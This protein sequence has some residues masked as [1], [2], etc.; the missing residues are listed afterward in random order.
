MVENELLNVFPQQNLDKQLKITYSGGTITN[1]E[2][3]QESMELTES[4]CSEEELR[5]G[6]CE[7]SCFKIRV[8]NVFQ[9]MQGEWIDVSMTLEGHPNCAH[10]IGHYKVASDVPTADRVWR[11]ITAYDAMYDIINADVVGWYDSIVKDENAK[12][13]MREFRRSFVQHF[14]LEEA[15]PSMALVN[16]NMTIQRTV[17]AE[18]ISGKDMLSCICEINGCFPHIDQNGKMKYIY[19]AQYIQGL[20]PADDLYPDHAPYYLPY[21]QETGHLYPKDPKGFNVGAH[22][23]YISC[24]YEDFLT[25][26]IKRLQVHMQENE[27][28]VIV[29]QDAVGNSYK[30]AGNFLAY[31]KGSDELR[32]IAENIMAKIR[33]VIYRPY[34]AVTQG[35]LCVEVGDTVRLGTRYEAVESYVL[36]RHLTGIQALRDTLTATGV[37]EYTEQVNDVHT[38]ILELRGKSNTLSR[39]IE[40]TKSELKDDDAALSTRITQ[41]AKDIKAEAEERSKADEELSASITINAEAIE[42]EVNDRKKQG[43]ELS[44]RIT[45][46]AKN[47]ELFVQQVSGQSGEISKAMIEMAAGVIEAKVSKNGSGNTNNEVSFQLSAAEDEIRIKA[48]RLFVE[49]GYIESSKYF[50]GEIMSKEKSGKW[51]SDS[52][53]SDTWGHTTYINLDTGDFSFGGGQFYYW[54]NEM[55]LDGNFIASGTITGMDFVG[56]RL[57]NSD[58]TNY[59]DFGS[60]QMLIG[61]KSGGDYLE[62][63]NGTLTFSGDLS[64]AGGTFSGKLSAAGGTFSGDISAANGTFKGAV[65]SNDAETNTTLL[66]DDGAIKF[67]LNDSESG[68]LSGWWMDLDTN[69]NMLVL[70]SYDNIV[71]ASPKVSTTTTPAPNSSGSHITYST[72]LNQTV[73]VISDITNNDDSTISWHYANLTFT[74]G[75][76]TGVTNGN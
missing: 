57:Q 14:G 5:F 8:A 3:C 37:E 58:G 47:I 54:N 68:Y 11:D 51:E 27:I 72:G 45:Q 69:R 16:D 30:I 48:G 59:L 67:S 40:E 39:T 20:Y 19:L 43:D 2:I 26:E 33:G 24:K 4:L 9:P 55:H 50:A 53:W 63:N 76:L 71:L 18:Q 61:N 35:N 25:K 22:G 1:K 46:T 28:G 29:N 15:D 66:L 75:L 44:T 49:G 42:T 31:N 56:S 17:N 41:N 6:T 60:N 7:A 32:P 74:N 36:Q 70:S 34:E 73:Q 38:S 10:K 12:V 65:E 13:S 23:A 62:Y 21:M 64:A 52:Q